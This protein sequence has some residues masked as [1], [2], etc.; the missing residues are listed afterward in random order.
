[1]KKRIAL[2]SGSMRRSSPVVVVSLFILIVALGF[3]TVGN[4]KRDAKTVFGA[5]LYVVG[6]RST[7]L[8]SVLSRNNPYGRETERSS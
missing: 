8:V 3:S 2:V 6:G 1:M 5:M 7:T 4:T